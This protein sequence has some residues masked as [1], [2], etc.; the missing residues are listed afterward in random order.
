MVRLNNRGIVND[1]IFFVSWVFFFGIFAFAMWVA[2]QDTNTEFQQTDALS[3]ESKALFA[4]QATAYNE[5]MDYTFLTVFVAIVL[6]TLILS[7]FLR[8]QPALFW[9]LWIVTMVL[10]IV[11]GYLA[12]AWGVFTSSGKFANAVGT[13]PIT[14]HILSN[15]LTYVVG[16]SLLMLAVYFA[17]PQG[18]DAV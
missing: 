18:G 7:Y 5:Y 3:A 4:D 2:W 9:P 17:K 10:G 11:A 6:G 12:N 13:F 8:T 1:Q 16:M 14:N 15:Y